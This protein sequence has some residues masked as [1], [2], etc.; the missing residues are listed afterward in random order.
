MAMHKALFALGIFI[1]T[2]LP[3]H[4]IETP[5]LS[6]GQTLFES[7]ELGNRGKSCATC[8]PQGKGLAKIGDFNDVE[9]KDIINAC[10]RDALGAEMMSTDSQEMD[11][12]LAYV[13]KFQ[14]KQ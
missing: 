2:A 7:P 9:L 6:L 12:L 3:A 11:A 14:A 8:H 10:L 1:I 13:R 4:A 5:S